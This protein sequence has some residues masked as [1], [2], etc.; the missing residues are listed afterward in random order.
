MHTHTSN[1]LRAHREL[2]WKCVDVYECMRCMSIWYV[3][4]HIHANHSAPCCHEC[5][6]APLSLSVCITTQ[7]SSITVIF[8]AHSPHRNVPIKI[9]LKHLSRCTA[10]SRLLLATNT[11]VHML[12]VAL[13]GVAHRPS[14]AS[15]HFRWA[16]FQL[17]A[18]HQFFYKKNC[19]WS[20]LPTAFLFASCFAH[21]VMYISIMSICSKLLVLQNIMRSAY[22]AYC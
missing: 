22:V 4:V 2:R 1:H 9:Q 3:K 19:S 10:L 20:M 16:V 11:Y 13:V 7:S 15:G 14:S 6:Y 18:N 21:V 8:W 17:K 5:T 12:V